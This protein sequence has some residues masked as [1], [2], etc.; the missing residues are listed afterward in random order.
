[1]GIPECG[2]NSDNDEGS[3]SNESCFT[4]CTSNA[5]SS[6]R[7]FFFCRLVFCVFSFICAVLF[8]VLAVSLVLV[9]VFVL[10]LMFLFLL[11]CY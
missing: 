5:V 4:T 11:L 9:F 2:H 3:T 8:L 1:M 7:V 6:V 10:V